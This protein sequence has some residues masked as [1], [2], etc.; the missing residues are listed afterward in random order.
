MGGWRARNKSWTTHVDAESAGT[1]GRGF[2]SRRLHQLGACEAPSGGAFCADPQ[3]PGLLASC[4]APG[5]RERQ[6]ERQ[7]A[8]AAALSN[9]PA[10]PSGGS[11][12]KG[13]AYSAAGVLV[14]LSPGRDE[15]RGQAGDSRFVGSGARYGSTHSVGGGV[16]HPPRRDRASDGA[17]TPRERAA[18]TRNPTTGALATVGLSHVDRVR[19]NPLATVAT[20]ILSPDGT[21]AR[22]PP[23]P[24]GRRPRG[25]RCGAIL[26]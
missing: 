14:P 4:R 3:S 20:S 16:F 1:P 18:A 11:S 9:R 12:Q 8:H 24:P 5:G 13:S 22:L 23:P 7:L 26:S 17:G 25:P 15:R 21:R 6:G 10:C 2:D 19:L